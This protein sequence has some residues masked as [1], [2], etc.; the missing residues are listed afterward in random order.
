MASKIVRFT[1][2]GR[3]T[4]VMVKPLMTLQ[5]LLRE[6]LGY[7]ATKA[8][9]KQGGCGSCTVLL[10]GMPVMSC[11]MPVEDVAGQE[12][13]T[14]EGIKPTDGLHPIQSAFYENFAMQ[15][16]FC[17]SGMILVTK[18]LLDRNASPSR[19]DIIEAL[20]GNYCRCT[21][22]EPIIK[23]V[24]DAAQRMNGRE[25]EARRETL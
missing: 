19:Q 12:V 8:G 9:C 23:A 20:T 16:G 7:T 1:L 22:Y 10:N 5:S 4:E 11:L 17:S 13:I 6:Q 24:E 25:K 2:N 15:C 21:C 3:D 14:L 18:A